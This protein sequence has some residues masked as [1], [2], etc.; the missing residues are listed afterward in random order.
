MM[1]DGELMR[2]FMLMGVPKGHERLYETT[3][4]SYGPDVLPVYL[5]TGLDPGSNT[6][7]YFSIETPANNT[8]AY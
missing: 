1:V 6:P 8:I 7:Y 4:V 2:I 5:L 3:Q